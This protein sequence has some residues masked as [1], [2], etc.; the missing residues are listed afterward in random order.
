MQKLLGHATK[1]V[2]TT[3]YS[4]ETNEQTKRENGLLTFFDG[5]RTRMLLRQQLL[6]VLTMHHILS[7]IIE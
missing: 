5:R 1:M 4:S 2:K 3:G 7:I 6:A